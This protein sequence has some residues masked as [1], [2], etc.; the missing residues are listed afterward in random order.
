MKFLGMDGGNSNDVS[1]II[2]I[3]VILTFVVIATPLIIILVIVLF[4]LRRNKRK[5]QGNTYCLYRLLCV[6][7]FSLYNYL[8]GRHVGR[9][10]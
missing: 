3:V 5:S 7:S 6:T 1:I 2:A 9:V 4:L 8:R 10:E